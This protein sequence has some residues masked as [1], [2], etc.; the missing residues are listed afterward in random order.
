MSRNQIYTTVNEMNRL[1]GSS[2]PFLFG[3]DFEL[4]NAF[5]IKNPFMQSEVLFRS[6]GYANYSGMYISS[7]TNEIKL[8]IGDL[9]SQADYCKA[10]E[11]IRHAFERGDSYLCNYTLKTL[12]RI[13]VSL[14]ELFLRTNSL[15]GLCYHDDFI[16][17]SPERFVKIS[18]GLIYSNPMKGTIDASL[19]DA[20][21]ILLQDYKE[22]CEH[23]TIV[24]LIQNDLS[25]LASN[26]RLKHFKYIDRLQTSGGELL[27]MSSEIVGELPDNY[28]SH[29]GDIIFSLLPAGSVSGAPKHSSVELIKSVEQQKRGYYTGIFGYFDGKS[30]DS[31]VLI[32][33]IEREGE[34][35]FYR[36]GGGITINSLCEQ[37]YQEMMQKIYIPL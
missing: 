14:K 28:L 30:L 32:R 1:G 11:T 37:E 13:N 10:F 9:M 17:F 6:P 2:I 33:F 8:E 15:F 25:K 34:Q 24:D 4:E 19:P 20:E 16:S 36:S 5:L 31:A 12:I 18:N 22:D 35:L 7:F 23:N 3:F 21:N 27:Q 29:L 26:L